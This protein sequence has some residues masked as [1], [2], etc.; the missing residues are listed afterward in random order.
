MDRCNLVVFYDNSEEFR[1]FAI[2]K[3]GVIVR[4]S[5]VI[6]AWFSEQKFYEIT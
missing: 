1:R 5:R 4:L 3:D 2:Y 6:P